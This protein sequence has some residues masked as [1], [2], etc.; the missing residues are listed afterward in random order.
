MNAM[1]CA[2]NTEEPPRSTTYKKVDDEGDENCVVVAQE[3]VGDD[4]AENRGQVAG[5]GPHSDFG[6][7][8]QVAAMEDFLQVHDQVRGD[9][10]E[11]CALQ[12]FEP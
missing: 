9:A 8:G 3:G 6:R 2:P 12:A 1:A 10:K 4:G 11:P 7:A 5:A